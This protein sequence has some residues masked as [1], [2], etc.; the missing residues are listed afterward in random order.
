MSDLDKISLSLDVEYL[1][2]RACHVSD[3]NKNTRMLGAGQ[4]Y[5]NTSGHCQ[6]LV[7]TFKNINPHQLSSGPLNPLLLVYQGAFCFQIKVL[8]NEMTGMTFIRIVRAY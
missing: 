5:L 3:S 4:T 6:D 2:A 8:E 1:S 7:F